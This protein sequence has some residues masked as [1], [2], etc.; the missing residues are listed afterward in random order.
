MEHLGP[1]KHNGASAAQSSPVPLIDAFLG[2]SHSG[3]AVQRQ[4]RYLVVV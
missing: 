1:F 4:T 3:T 2:V